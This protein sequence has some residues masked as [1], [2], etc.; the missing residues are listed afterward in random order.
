MMIQSVP[1][2]LDSFTTSQIIGLWDNTK[3]RFPRSRERI[4]YCNSVQQ[5]GE[6]VIRPDLATN[7]DGSSVDPHR[8]PLTMLMPQR[9]QIP[10]G[11]TNRMSENVPQIERRRT[12]TSPQASRDAEL[13][14]TFLN[15]AVEETFDVEECYGKAIE[16]AEYLIVV[17]PD[18]THFEDSPSFMDTIPEARF[19]KL[20]ET[21]QESY[22]P[23]DQ[24]QGYYVRVDKQGRRQMDPQWSRD[25]QG[26]ARDSQGFTRES[27]VQSRKAWREAQKAYHASIPPWIVRIVSAMD[28]VPIFTRGRGKKRHQAIGVVIRTLYDIEELLEQDYRWPHRDEHWNNRQLIP[29]GWDPL[30][31]YGAGGQIYLYEAHLM[32]QGHPIIAYSVGG[33]T[34]GWGIP[35]QADQQVDAKHDLLEEYG[36]PHLFLHYGYGLHTASDNPDLRGVPVLYPIAKMLVGQE[37]LIVATNVH[38]WKNAFGGYFLPIDPK[39][40]RETYLESN[41]SLKKF[42]MPGS[43]EVVPVPGIPVPAASAEISQTARYLIEQLQ[44]HLRQ[45]ESDELEGHQTSGHGLNVASDIEQAANRQIPESVRESVEFVAE[46]IL[47]VC[48]AIKK[49]FGVPVGLWINEEIEPAADVPSEP[50]DHWRILELQDRWVAGVYK[51]T[52]VFPRRGNLAEVSLLSQLQKQ[53]QATMYDLLEARG[54]ENPTTEI[55][56]INAEQILIGTPEGKM[57]MLANALRQRGEAEKAAQLEA[58]LNGRL[59]QF[60]MPIAAMAGPPQQQGPGGAAAPAGGPGGTGQAGSMAGTQIPDI[61]ASVRGGVVAGE[62]G[63]RAIMSDA[64]TQVRGG[65]PQGPQ[66]GAGGGM[67]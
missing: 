28:C 58:Q 62:V 4:Q 1:I 10:I 46:S 39:A 18:T 47:E 12:G 56:K 54:K 66:P 53:G 3:R 30:N 21:E 43:G 55:A 44:L 35:G 52:A 37:S 13:L 24:R 65:E 59:S 23:Y 41:G 25:G 33:E 14:A 36:I 8:D 60:G 40:P 7:S 17:Q 45:A 63:Q 6:G 26:R 20:E 61:A 51:V 67:L 5:G 31:T 32:V 34:T 19:K 2:T 27:K 22:R 50:Q 64:R 49:T 38:T 9:W 11:M 48:D 57:A 16:D 29:T 15:V 42:S